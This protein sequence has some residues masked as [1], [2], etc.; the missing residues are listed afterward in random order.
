MSLRLELRTKVVHIIIASLC[1]VP[2]DRLL[3]GLD[4]KKKMSGLFTAAVNASLVDN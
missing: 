3:D 4:L 2:M 1:C